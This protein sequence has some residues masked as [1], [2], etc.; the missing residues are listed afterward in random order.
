MKEK[1]NINQEETIE[2]FIDEL[3]AR[4]EEPRK[5]FDSAYD[6]YINLLVDLQTTLTVGLENHAMLMTKDSTNNLITIISAIAESD[7]VKIFDK[8]E[9]SPVTSSVRTAIALW[10][11]TCYTIGYYITNEMD[12]TDM[13]DTSGTVLHVI[14]SIL[15]IFELLQHAISFANFE[16]TI[17]KEEYIALYNKF[18]SLM[19]TDDLTAVNP[20]E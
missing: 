13:E 20:E 4:Y 10:D 16:D 15:A 12:K 1:N 8:I 5:A 17:D 7:L 14:A 19:N 2:R 18:Q 9:N 3:N 11:S 6:A